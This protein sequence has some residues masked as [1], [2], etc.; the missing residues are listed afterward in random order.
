MFVNQKLYQIYFDTLTV[1][2]FGQLA[3]NVTLKLFIHHLLQ[4]VNK[5]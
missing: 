2:K 3:Y 5:W 1:M 4:V